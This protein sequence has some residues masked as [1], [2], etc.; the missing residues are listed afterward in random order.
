MSSADCNELDEEEL[1]HSSCTVAC[2]QAKDRIQF[3][4]RFIHEKKKEKKIRE[5]N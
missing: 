4:L 1:Q 2:L 5:K 3:G